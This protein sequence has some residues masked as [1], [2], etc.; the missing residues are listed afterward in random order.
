MEI[1]QQFLEV[2][3]LTGLQFADF[4]KDLKNSNIL[5]IFLPEIAILETFKHSEIH[6]PEGNCF[7]HTI[8]AL[9]Q[10]K[11]P[12]QIVNI[13]ILL[14]DVGKPGTY[15]F[16]NNKHTYYGHETFG[17]PIV[18]NICKRLQLSIEITNVA[19]FCCE[20]HMKFH[21]INKMKLAKVKNLV[22]N[23]YFN[24]LKLV[25]EADSKCRLHAFNSNDWNNIILKIERLKD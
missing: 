6:H 7:Q 24:Y 5:E 18:E 2:S 17:I 21:L 16:Q 3:K 19:K 9:Q 4:I 14:H 8:A 25:A 13:A 12:N 23:K 1:I 15:K 10:N 22:N 20:N 11:V